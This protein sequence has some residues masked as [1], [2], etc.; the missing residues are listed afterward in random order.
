VELYLPNIAL[1]R[2]CHVVGLPSF[3]A[4]RQWQKTGK[5][6]QPFCFEVKGVGTVRVCWSLGSLEGREW[7]MGEVLLD[8]YDKA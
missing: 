8:T 7:H 5:A 2:Y 6:K 1:Q 3:P 4:R